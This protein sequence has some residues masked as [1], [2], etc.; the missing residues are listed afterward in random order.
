MRVTLRFRVVCGSTRSGVLRCVR[1]EARTDS[2]L[3]GKE[4]DR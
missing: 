3:D 2:M 4:N 1:P